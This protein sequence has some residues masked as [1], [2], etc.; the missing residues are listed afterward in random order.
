M[1]WSMLQLLGI[2]N[3]ALS[4]FNEL[5]GGQQQKVLIARALAQDTDHSA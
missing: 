2:E 3:L 4:A 1:V 5:S